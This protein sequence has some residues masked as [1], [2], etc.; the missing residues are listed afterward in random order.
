MVRDP[1][2]PPPCEYRDPGAPDHRPHRPLRLRQV[3]LPQDPGPDERPGGGGEDHRVGAVEGG[4][5]QALGVVGGGGEYHLKAGDMGAQGAPILAMLGAVL[6]AHAH[7]EHHG[8]L[9]HTGA[10]GLPLGQLVEHLVPGPALAQGGRD[11]S[12]RQIQYRQ[13][14]IHIVIVIRSKC[15]SL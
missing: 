15:L 13:R 6:G 3:H 4:L 7:A 12:R 11:L 14:P 2:G 9:Q 5:H 1:P 10:H 8:H